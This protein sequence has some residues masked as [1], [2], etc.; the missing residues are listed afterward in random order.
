[1]KSPLSAQNLKISLFG[2]VFS[3]A[4]KT[5]MAEKGPMRQRTGK[6]LSALAFFKVQYGIRDSNDLYA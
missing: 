4:L 3:Q 5:S 2:H 1:M 6:H